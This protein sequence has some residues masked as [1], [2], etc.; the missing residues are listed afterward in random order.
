MGSLSTAGEA[1]ARIAY[2]S[3]DVVLSVQPTLEGDS[4]FSK[5]LNRLSAERVR[6]AVSGNNT[7]VRPVRHN[8]DP[9]L[10]AYYPLQNGQRVSV[11][12]SS[13]ILLSSIP[14]LY[15][16]ANYPIVIH[17]HLEPSE[18]ADFSVI[19]SIR[20]CGFSFLH[21]E[22]I[23]EAQDIALTGHAL[24]VRSGKGVIHF[25]DLS[26]SEKNEPVAAE[27]AVLVKDIL[28]IGGAAVSH[29]SEG[30]SQTL[31][32]DSGRVATVTD[33]GFGGPV[34]TP[35]PELTIPSPKSAA[36]SVDP[37]SV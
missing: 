23:Q 7:E 37:S 3:S 19:S 17:V 28:E 11:T 34:I 15:R 2:L 20:Q 36:H 26:N 4:I 16:L 24:A 8:E 14:H 33:Q 32:A 5:A 6:G 31:Y 9:L 27:D 10:S 29:S 18:F 1:V 12:T 35:A 25:F 22:T 21:S 13:T 30:A